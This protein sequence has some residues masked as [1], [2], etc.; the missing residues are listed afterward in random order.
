M[1]RGVDSGDFEGIRVA[2]VL[3]ERR[4]GAPYVAITD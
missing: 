1:P 3:Q 4:E 2:L